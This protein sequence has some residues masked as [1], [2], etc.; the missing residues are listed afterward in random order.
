MNKNFPRKKFAAVALSLLVLLTVALLL[1]FPLGLAS[2]FG[3]RPL[4]HACLG[5]QVKSGKITSLLAKRDITFFTTPARDFRYFVP[6]TLPLGTP[7][8]IGMDIWNGE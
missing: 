1:F 2:S 6:Q 5:I 8:C 3:I 7:L 4:T